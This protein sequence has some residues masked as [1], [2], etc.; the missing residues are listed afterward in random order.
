M[1][2]SH[3]PLIKL[4][5]RACL[6]EAAR[7][8]VLKFDP[9]WKLVDSSGDPAYYGIDP[10][11]PEPGLGHVRDLFLGISGND[12]Q[13]FPQVELPGGRSAH[14]HLVPDIGGCWVILLDA[15]A[16]VSRQ[17]AVQQ[18]G[19]EAELSGHEKSRALR[20]LKQVR[21]ELEQQRTELQEADALKTALMATLSHEFRTPLTS[22]F[23]YIHLLERRLAGDENGTHALRAIRRAATHLQ[24]LSENLLEY[25]RD[26]AGG[27]LLDPQ[28]LDLSRLGEEL[29]DMFAPLAV[30][31]GLAFEL[32]TD[33]YGAGAPVGDALKLRQVAINLIAN[34]L[35]YTP[36][37]RVD[38]TLAWNGKHV[39]VEVRD[40][41]IGV[42]AAQRES[43]F[44][45]FD[46]GDQKGSR[47]AGL[48][49]AIVKR[50]VDA[51]GG[52]V[53]V[54]SQ[55][56]R[57]STFRVELPPLGERAA[58]APEQ[59]EP[60][61]APRG[62]RA[63]VADDDPDIRDLLRLMLED[64]GWRVELA[65]DARETVERTKSGA[66]DL[67]VV[68]VQMPG[69]SGNAAVYQLR[70]QGFKGRIITLS[71][72]PTA[73]ARNAALQAGADAFM[74]K[75]LDLAQFLRT[76]LG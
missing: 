23:G 75:P 2:D 25:A 15:T 29:R 19:N 10:R 55:L 3:P 16:D 24:A 43:I 72:T 38:A 6:V 32:R 21:S 7:P 69:L 5:L 4:Y 45:A 36:Q 73:D 30:E 51:M 50:L 57:G 68:D 11:D 62:A 60:G 18:V 35:R 8:V 47:G 76:T 12:V 9:T 41:G 54:D 56:G 63:I 28:R 42:P 37:G 70:S 64:Q 20:R 39:V 61:R 17:R 58:A 40:T 26:G 31:Q 52:R 59:A 34:A 22:I 66:P 48:G 71:A 27:S 67:L 74:T 46:R 1:K 33:V 53:T 49:L 65:R 14:V 44:E 13:V